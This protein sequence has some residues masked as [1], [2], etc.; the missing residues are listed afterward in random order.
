MEHEFRCPHCGEDRC[1]TIQL[2]AMDSV[3]A[4]YF[5]V[6]CNDTW[7]DPSAQAICAACDH[8]AEFADFWL[9]E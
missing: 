9:S 2:V 4:G 6:E 8:T 7:L 5:N 1:H 3:E